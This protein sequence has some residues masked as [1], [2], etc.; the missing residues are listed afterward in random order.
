MQKWVLQTLDKIGHVT[1][2]QQALLMSQLAREGNSYSITPALYKE[3]KMGQKGRNCFL[4]TLA[5]KSLSG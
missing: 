4:W 5:L 2:I 1:G 3:D